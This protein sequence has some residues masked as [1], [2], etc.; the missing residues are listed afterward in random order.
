MIK[1]SYTYIR[2]MSAGIVE[3]SELFESDDDGKGSEEGMMR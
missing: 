3:V 2:K 1:S